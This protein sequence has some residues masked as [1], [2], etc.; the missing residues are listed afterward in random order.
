MNNNEAGTTSNPWPS[1]DWVAFA[2]ERGF[3]AAIILAVAFAAIALRGLRQLLAARD[4]DTALRASALLATAVAA[5]VA[6]LF[7]AVLMIALAH[8]PGLGCAGCTHAW[9]DVG[10]QPGHAGS[11]A[12][13]GAGRSVVD[14][15]W[16]AAQ[17]IT[18]DRDGD[19]L[20]ATTQRVLAGHCRAHRSGQLSP[21]HEAGRSG[22]QPGAALQPRA[23]RARP[24]AQRTTSAR[25]QPPL[26]LR[27]SRVV[28]I[29]ETDPRMR[30][31]TRGREGSR[32]RIRGGYEERTSTSTSTTTT[33][34]F[35]MVL[36]AVRLSDTTISPSWSFSYSYSYSSVDSFPN[37]VP[38]LILPLDPF[39]YPSSSSCSLIRCRNVQE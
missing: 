22:S 13:R 9:R 8:T 14:R 17:H 33:T 24:A 3:L 2:A 10:S 6:G 16:C 15:D 36:A 21:A 23:R 1:S 39:P 29:C 4:L 38:P 31:R 18:A 35:Q 27:A 20:D 11:S 25:S 32:G 30:M 34:R 37:P 5:I 26:R 28:V 7:D 19:L 12:R